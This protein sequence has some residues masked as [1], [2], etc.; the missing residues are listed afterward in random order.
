M[1][2]IIVPETQETKSE[3][4]LTALV[5]G[6]RGKHIE[7][8]SQREEERERGEDETERGGRGSKGERKRMKLEEEK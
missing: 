6:H 1:Q 4:P 3:D 5:Q 7:S 2:N 8:Q